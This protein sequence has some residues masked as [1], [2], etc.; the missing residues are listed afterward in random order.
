MLIEILWD[1]QEGS[2]K[3]KEVLEWGN[4]AEWKPPD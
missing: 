1:G 4:K 3:G 2:E